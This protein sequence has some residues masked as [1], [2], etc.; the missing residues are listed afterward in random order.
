MT[1]LKGLADAIA[2]RVQM[3]R[4][5]DF[6]LVTELFLLLQQVFKYPGSYEIIRPSL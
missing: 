1:P 6:I 5:I 4:M 2:A 3:R